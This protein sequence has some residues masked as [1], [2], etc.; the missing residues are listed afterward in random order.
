MLARLAQPVC[1][2]G[3]RGVHGLMDTA[4]VT[5]QFNV[6]FFIFL[7]IFLTQKLKG[8]IQHLPAQEGLLRQGQHVGRGRDGRRLLRVPLLLP[9]A[10]R[11]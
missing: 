5:R 9:A 1:R 7:I 3:R 8:Q 6:S 10:C 2:L 4:N 11:S